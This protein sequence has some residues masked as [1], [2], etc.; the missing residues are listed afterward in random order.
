MPVSHLSA[1]IYIMKAKVVVL[2]VFTY[3]MAI[4]GGAYGVGRAGFVGLIIGGIGGWMVGYVAA[5]LIAGKPKEQTPEPKRAETLHEQPDYYQVPE[6]LIKK[7]DRKILKVMAVYS[8]SPFWTYEDG[9]EF[10]MRGEQL[11]I[12]DSLILAFSDWANRYNNAVEAQKSGR[13]PFTF[14]DQKSFSEDGFLLAKELA[15]QIKSE[16]KVYYHNGVL[17]K[18]IEIS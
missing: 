18:D 11:P 8:G 3:L 1:I 4:I 9:E 7:E 17:A 6:E 10:M 12:S 13:K 2:H 14:E 16:Y 5:V 15:E